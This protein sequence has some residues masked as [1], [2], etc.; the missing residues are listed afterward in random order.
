[1][2]A[3]LGIEKQVENL[4]SKNNVLPAEISIPGEAPLL[5]KWRVQS[6]RFEAKQYTDKVLPT[7]TVV[8]AA[9]ARDSTACGVRE[10]LSRG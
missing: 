2:L 6:V 7:I 3:A 5:L 4:V 1:M 10:L 9:R 8:R